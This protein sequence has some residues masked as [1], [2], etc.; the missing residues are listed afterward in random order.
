MGGSINEQLTWLQKVLTDMIN[1]ITTT[2]N[3]F[4]NTESLN[5]ETVDQLMSDFQNTINDFTS[6]PSGSGTTP[7][8]GSSNPNTPVSSK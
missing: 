1:E 5:T 4:S 3:S 6:P 2:V 7:P 8:S